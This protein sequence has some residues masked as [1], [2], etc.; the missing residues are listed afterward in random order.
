MA[1]LNTKNSTKQQLGN[2]RCWREKKK[3]I[4]G[5][6]K[7]ANGVGKYFSKK[8]FFFKFSKKKNSQL[9]LLASQQFLLAII[10]KTLQF[11]KFFFWFFAI[12]FAGF[13]KKKA[14]KTC[15]RTDI[16]WLAKIQKFPKM[17]SKKK[18]AI[19]VPTTPTTGKAYGWDG[20]QKCPLN[21]FNFVGI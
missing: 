2:S 6:T 11:F 17:C 5:P 20:P 7:L 1:E 3:A 21:F 18:T 8:H 19:G 4:A 10:L 12:F 9:I 13:E 14:I 16:F 15:W